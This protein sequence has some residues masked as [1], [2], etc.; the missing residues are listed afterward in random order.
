MRVFK[1]N[2]YIEWASRDGELWV[3]FCE[4]CWLYGLNYVIRSKRKIEWGCGRDGGEM[5]WRVVSVNELDG[6]EIGDG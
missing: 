3:E 2:D 1:I 6:S 4:K 5:G